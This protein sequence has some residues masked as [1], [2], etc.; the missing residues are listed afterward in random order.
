[1]NW[2]KEEKENKEQN[3][4]FRKERFCQLQQLLREVRYQHCQYGAVGMN[5]LYDLLRN[6]YLIGLNKDESFQKE[7]KQ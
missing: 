1:V 2:I 6:E 4:Y 7:N 5:T 3:N